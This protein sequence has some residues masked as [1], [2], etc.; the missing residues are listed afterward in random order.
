MTNVRS[1]RL[2]GPAFRA[3]DEVVLIKGPYVGTPGVFLRLKE[4]ASW[5]DITE[6]NGVVRSHP[7]AW[8]GA[9]TS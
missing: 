1:V 6:R 7:R 2:A 4:D 3:G 9:V 8:L 5:V